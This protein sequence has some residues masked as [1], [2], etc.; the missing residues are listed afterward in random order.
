MW[1]A[2]N[3]KKHSLF[4]LYESQRLVGNDVE[5]RSRMKR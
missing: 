5:Q 2:F 1:A 4:D 3:S